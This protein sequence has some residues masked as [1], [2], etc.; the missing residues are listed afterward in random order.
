MKAVAYSLVCVINWFAHNALWSC[1][2]QIGFDVVNVCVQV[3]PLCV[4]RHQRE[5]S[6]MPVKPNNGF[7][8]D[9]C[10]IV[11]LAKGNPPL[12]CQENA[13]VPVTSCWIH[14]CLHGGK[15]TLHLTCWSQLLCFWR[16]CILG[17]ICLSVSYAVVSIHDSDNS[18]RLGVT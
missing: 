12:L 3:M 1:V 17:V 18:E 8:N 15:C 6:H 10:S 11:I 2:C 7:V 14:P 4:R 13:K 16:E 5:L 9:W